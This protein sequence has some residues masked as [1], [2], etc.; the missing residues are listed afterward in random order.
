MELKQS[1]DGLEASF[2]STHT[3]ANSDSLFLHFPTF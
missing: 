2:F 3:P 1:G